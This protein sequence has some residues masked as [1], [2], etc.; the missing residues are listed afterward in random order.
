MN[1]IKILMI[2]LSASLLLW[3]CSDDD[4]PTNGNIATISLSTDIIQVDK[5][6]GNA[7]VTVT[8]SD[9]WRLSGVS[10]WVRPSVTSGKN[11]DVVTFTADPNRLDEKRTAAF[12]FFTGSTVV[13][14]KVESE[15]AYILNLLSDSNP[16]VSKEGNLVMIELDT[17]V[18][19]IDIEMSNGSEEWLTFDKRIDFAE[20]AT[21]RFSITNNEAFIDRSA[22]ITFS[23]P[24]VATPVS[25]N[26]IQSKTD[27]ITPEN[28]TL[29]YDA[30][31]RTMS[32]NL[33]YNVDYNIS[34]PKGESWISHKT[35]STPV[36]GDNG[37]STVTLTFDLA[38]APASRRGVINVSKTDKSMSRD[39][40]VYQ[41]NASEEPVEFPDENLR[42]ILVTNGWIIMTEDSKYVIL[43]E[44]REA[45]HFVNGNYRVKI[46]D[47]SGIENFPNLTSLALS[48]CESMSKL[49]ISG[50]HNVS[51]LTYM[52]LINCTEFNFG[53]NPI[54][55]FYPNGFYS[56]SYVDSYKF[57][58][59]KLE[60]LNVSMYEYYGRY[61]KVTSL[62]V[63]ECPALT[64]LN[65]NRVNIRTIYM[66]VGQTIPNLTLNGSTEIVYK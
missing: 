1:S 30:E 59:S 25:V 52:D 36:V 10:D 57:I 2:A 20:K 28:E 15:G 19:D 21:M 17:N 33:T 63:S 55:S 22:T 46:S 39:I 53:D 13:P 24:L 40:A 35:T 45:T 43:E 14:L 4:E 27:I 56:Y 8:S 65:A 60:S 26:L 6:G 37:L 7:T 34:F 5:N 62:D 58:S 41:V 3:S 61:D 16:Y 11:G 18:A 12:K 38:A 47:L 29:M 48:N 9:D 66:K 64:T 49:D 23:S 31:A 51:E 42:Q 44:G 54:T 50:L 32:F